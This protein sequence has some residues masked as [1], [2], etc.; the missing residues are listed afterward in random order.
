MW[1]IPM[2]LDVSRSVR[3]TLESSWDLE[4][5]SRI[6]EQSLMWRSKPSRWQTWLQRLKKVGWMQ[7]LSGRIL[8]PLMENRFETEYTSSLA[9]IPA[10]RSMSPAN[11]RVN[12]TLDTFG[13][14]LKESLRQL[15]L[16][17]DFSRTSVGTLL[18]D[19]R[20]FTEVYEIWVTRLRRDC[21]RRQ[22]A[23]LRTNGSDC[24]SWPTMGVGDA[25]SGQTKPSD[26]RC[27][28]R[29]ESLRV[30]V[31]WLTPATV[32]MDRTPEGMQKRIYYRESIG[33]H[34]VE[35][36][37]QEQVINWPTPAHRDYRSQH[38]ENSEAFRA[39]LNKPEGVSLVEFMQRQSGLPAP[40]SPSTNGKSQELWPTPESR[41]QKGYHNQKDGSVKEKLG[42]QAGKGKLNPAWVCGLQ[43]IFAYWTD[44]Y[45]TPPET[46]VYNVVLGEKHYEAVR[47]MLSVLSEEVGTEAIQRKAG[48]FWYFFAQEILQSG[49]LCKG[50]IERRSR[51]ISII[52]KSKQ[53]SEKEVRQ[54]PF[55]NGPSN[56]PQGLQ[57][58]EQQ[59]KEF[60]DSMRFLPRKMA[61]AEW[62]DG[63]K[64]IKKN[65]F[66]MWKNLPYSPWDV[67]NALSTS[68]KV[69]ESASDKEIGKWVLG[70]CKRYIYWQESQQRTPNR[71]D[72][73]RLC[74][75]GVVPQCA[76]KA[77]V[78]LVKYFKQSLDW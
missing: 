60:D 52:E 36:G 41:N 49:L 66:C 57:Y 20:T 8:K 70:G 77:W 62:K 19:T 58:Q 75:N 56:T 10:S 12:Q 17:M 35:G 27:G 11:D 22:S 6:C 5:L 28:G 64:K 72:Q 68:K 16:F 44:L 23:V 69:W 15:D 29:Q 25:E 47:E 30:A 63:I 7:L 43:G 21:L 26:K 42:T 31:N 53:V 71:V 18:V 33:R 54:L 32:Q 45:L 40:D 1:I 78:E 73:L 4:K 74:G 37:L 51:E 39:R 14:I 48:R 55:N 13:R 59:T 67:C 3:A 34:Y 50:V 2:N 76:A 38:A 65:L 46:T 24:L 9:V 61:L